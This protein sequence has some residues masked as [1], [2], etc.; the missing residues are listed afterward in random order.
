M[1]DKPHD[2]PESLAAFDDLYRDEAR[3]AI[4]TIAAGEL[5]AG[6]SADALAQ[7]YAEKGKPDFVLA[8]LLGSAIPDERKRE[9]YATAHEQ[10]ALYIEQRAHEFDR[11]FHRP[12]PLLATE[13]ANDRVMA[14]RIR[15]GMPPSKGRGRQIPLI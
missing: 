12:F 9:L 13:A 3:Q 10:R 11:R 1:V 8:Y 15:A 5:A 4:L 6:A 7:Q 2:T 14:R